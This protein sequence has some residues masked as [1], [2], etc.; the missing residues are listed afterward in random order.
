M[1]GWKVAR[2]QQPGPPQAGFHF[3]AGAPV[4][5][6]LL[7]TSVVVE[8]T[9]CCMAKDARPL[10]SRRPTL[11]L[12]IAHRLAQMADRWRGF[13][14]SRRYLEEG[15]HRC[16]PPLC[17][18]Q[19]G[20]DSSFSRVQ[21][22]VTLGVDVVEFPRASDEGCA[23]SWLNIGDGN[24]AVAA[25]WQDLQITRRRTSAARCLVIPSS[26]VSRPS[27]LPPPPLSPPFP[28]SPPSPRPTPLQP[29][30]AMMLMRGRLELSRCRLDQSS[31]PKRASTPRP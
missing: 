14:W 3:A 23:L 29:S 10:V 18:A 6:I 2:S 19:R 22:H 26:S 28:P 15:S 7:L 1:S 30:T 11:K 25:A 17:C 4:N 13:G 8:L 31:H 5:T 20:N 9:G 16:E 27:S 21:A 12:E 24:G